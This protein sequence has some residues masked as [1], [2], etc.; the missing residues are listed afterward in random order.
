MLQLIT[1]TGLVLRHSCKHS[2]DVLAPRSQH[3]LLYGPGK[4]CIRIIFLNHRPV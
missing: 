3:I 2:S 1:V 4:H